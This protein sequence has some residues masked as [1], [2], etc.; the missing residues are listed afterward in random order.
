MGK[1]IVLSYKQYISY[2]G[3]WSNVNYY[4]SVNHPIPTRGDREH[5]GNF[6]NKSACS[7]FN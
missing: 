1:K 2:M 6:K 5:P 4:K 7:P 3:G